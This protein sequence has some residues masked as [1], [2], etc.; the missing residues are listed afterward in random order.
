MINYLEKQILPKSDS[1]ARE[2][3]LS[4]DHYLLQNGVLYYVRDSRM[5]RVKRQ[6][7]DISLQLVVPT[8]LRH[9]VISSKHGDDCAG[10]F[11]FRRT[12]MTLRLKYYW[13]GMYIDTR[14]FVFSCTKCNT[15][16]E[17]VRPVK[18]ELQPL[19]PTCVNE[20]WAVDLIN[21]PRTP[22]GS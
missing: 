16:K 7:D 13:K 1:E 12:Y 22:R 3:L 20:R 6:I 4:S 8:A 9:D 17:P 18:A 5:R 2:I 14:N 19:P 10:H 11:G 15:R 21:M